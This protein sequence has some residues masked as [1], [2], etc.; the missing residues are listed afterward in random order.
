MSEVRKRSGAVMV[1]LGMPI[2]RKLLKLV[3]HR[4]RYINHTVNQ[5]DIIRE[6]I[7]RQYEVEIERQKNNS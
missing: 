3:E 4:R 1:E 2:K 7:Q 6:L 5:S